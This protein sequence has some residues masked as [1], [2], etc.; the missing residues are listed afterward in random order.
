MNLLWNFFASSI[1]HFLQ[2]NNESS[3]HNLNDVNFMNIEE[4]S[5]IYDE[6]FK[7]LLKL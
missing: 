2:N 3:K 1:L 4:L 7:K 5:I 6:T